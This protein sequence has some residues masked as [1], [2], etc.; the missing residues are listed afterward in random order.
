LKEWIT[1]RNPVYETLQAK[2]R[3][4]FRLLL[5]SGVEDKGKILEIRRLAQTRKIP[6]EAVPREK[7]NN[8]AENPQGVALEVSAYPYVDISDILENAKKRNED[9]FVLVL[10]VIQNPQNLGSLL[11]TAEAAG[12]HGVIIPQHRSAEVTPA[13]VNAS[14]GA[15]EHMLIAQDNVARALEKL[16][17]E[18]AWV[19][20]L[21]GGECAQPAENISLTGPLALVVGNEGEGMRQ[22]VRD[23]CDYLMALPMR[24]HIESLN[25]AVAGSIAIYLALLERRKKASK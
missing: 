7:L 19:V 15:S 13:V 21:E 4:V 3:Q 11:R 8:M 16:K 1:G 9:L 17:E 22:L 10:D 2:R 24:G 25:A 23:T 20:G 12:I 6:I 5:A 14:A 18:G